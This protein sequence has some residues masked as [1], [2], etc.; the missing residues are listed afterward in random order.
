M[1]NIFLDFY[2]A[3]SKLPRQISAMVLILASGS[4]QDYQS[5]VPRSPELYVKVYQNVSQYSFS[6][7]SVQWTSNI[8]GSDLPLD[9]CMQFSSAVLQPSTTKCQVLKA[10]LWHTTLRFGN[11]SRMPFEGA[12]GWL[13]KDGPKG[14]HPF[15]ESLLL[16]I[17]VWKIDISMI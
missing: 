4:L 14:W 1:I 13:S 9:V 8:S 6:S 5:Q 16:S 11:S 12:T 3:I 17:Q 7:G 10:W 15:D 2:S